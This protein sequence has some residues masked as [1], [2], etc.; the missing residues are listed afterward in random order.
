MKMA[1]CNQYTT[2]TDSVT[3]L[4][5]PEPIFREIFNHLDFET[6]YL[7]KGVCQQI[8]EYADG[9]L[10][11]GGIFMLTTGRDVPSEFI[12]MYKQ[13]NKPPIIYSVLGDPY[14]YPRGFRATDLWSFGATL[15]NKMVVGIYHGSIENF[16]FSIHEFDP[17]RNEWNVI[18]PCKTKDAGYSSEV[19]SSELEKK[20][21]W[22]RE[23]PIISC[24]AIGD[25][26]LL[27]FYG[28]YL[29]PSNSV[30]LLS[31]HYNAT[32]KRTEYS[33]Q[34]LSIPSD[35]KALKEFTL[36]RVAF[37]Q[38]MLVGG[39]YCSGSTVDMV[40]NNVIWE[41]TR[42]KDK[43]TIHWRTIDLNGFKL[44][45]RP[46]CFKLMDSLYISG[47]HDDC[48]DGPRILN[49]P[50]LKEECLRG[51]IKNKR[52][53]G[54]DNKSIPYQNGS[55]VP[56]CTCCDIFSLSD[57]KYRKNMFSMPHLRMLDRH[58]SNVM[59]DKEEKFVL[60]APYQCETSPN[61]EFIIFTENN[62]FE[63]VPE[64]VS[65]RGVNMDWN[66]PRIVDHINVLL[67]IK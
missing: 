3:F 26:E 66:H 12:H 38:C 55:G 20:M 15:N 54:C 50:V 37:N 6:V 42:S 67:Q 33:L 34:N 43:G 60:I 53:D 17:W 28:G 25:S 65:K 49:N 36:L 14:P 57:G 16:K 47:G 19:S 48:F 44:R 21:Y 64:F 23:G 7:L 22:R 46:I 31:L 52:V 13:K 32:E 24:C 63:K 41:G 29:K 9:F 51:V 10:E 5:L 59:T 18:Q 4:D 8:K 39:V 40:H 11:L 2:T 27:L 61:Q 58:I 1:N 45:R 56:I 30:Q 35:L 62:G